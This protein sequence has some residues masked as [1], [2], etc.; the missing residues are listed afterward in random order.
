MDGRPDGWMLAI[1]SHPQVAVVKRKNWS[2][3][4]LHKEPL[5]VAL[6]ELKESIIQLLQNEDCKYAVM[7]VRK[8]L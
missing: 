5:H 2:S 7:P 3:L 1:C 6:L 8:P 4:K